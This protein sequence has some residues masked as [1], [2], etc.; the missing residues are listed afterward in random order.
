MTGMGVKQG[1]ISALFRWAMVFMAAAWA[2]SCQTGSSR[3]GVDP[4]TPE[5]QEQ[6]AQFKRDYIF[7]CSQEIA[8]EYSPEDGPARYTMMNFYN[9]LCTCGTERALAKFTD[10]DFRE[11]SLRVDDRATD[12]RMKAGARE[13]GDALV[14]NSKL[15]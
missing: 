14:R 12:R 15:P 11:V 8:D 2:T 10:A 5:G 1:L 3:S 9:R 6:I 4:N 7:K 13:C